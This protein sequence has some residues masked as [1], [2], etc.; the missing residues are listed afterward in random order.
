MKQRALLPVLFLLLSGVCI[1]YAAATG[2]SSDDPLISLSYLNGTFTNTVQQRIAALRSGASASA[3]VSADVWTETRLKSGDVLSGSTGTCVLPLAGGMT[4]SFSSGTVVDATSG[5][6]VPSGSA[7]A[8]RH[9]YLVAEDTVAD[10]TVSGKTAVLDYQGPYSLSYSSATDYNAVAEALKTIH[11]FRGSLTG[12][13]SGFDLEVSPTRLQALIMFIRLLGVEDE[14]LAYTGTTPFTDIQSGSEP[15]RY[16]GYAYSKGYTNGYTKTTFRPSQ[17]VNA[18]QYVEFVLRALG[19]SSTGTTDLTGTL[20][21]AVSCGVLTVSEKTVL[22]RDSFLRADLVYV[23]WYAL[24]AQ[25]SGAGQTLRQTLLSRG[26]FTENEN[27]SAAGLIS[28]S[29]IP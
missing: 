23:S 29:R 7:L 1:Y 10:F 22:A 13:G 21:R 9:R 14:A 12:Y 25:V 5:S 11:L 17:K 2:G 20:D 18:Y 28:G 3:A 8:V 24:D 15:A 27:S 26:I 16:V 6:E 4:I 19:Y